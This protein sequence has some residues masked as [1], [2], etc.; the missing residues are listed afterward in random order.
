MKNNLFIEEFSFYEIEYD[1]K[2][3]DGVKE[4]DIEYM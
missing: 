2:E 4:I 3:F 1:F